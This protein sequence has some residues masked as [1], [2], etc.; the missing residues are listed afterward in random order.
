MVWSV[1][2]N[3]LSLLLLTLCVA[4]DSIPNLTKAA[5]LGDRV[6]GVL[7][8]QIKSRLATHQA[9]RSWPSLLVLVILGLSGLVSVGCDSESS[10]PYVEGIEDSSNSD[11]DAVGDL[12][13]QDAT[14]NQCAPACE[15]GESCDAQGLP[16]G[17]SCDGNACGM[18][19]TCQ[20]GEC[21]VDEDPCD[22]LNPCTEDLCDE[23]L[24]CIHVD[25]TGGEK[26]CGEGACQ[27]SIQECD[28]GNLMECPEVVISDEICDGLDNDCDGEIDEE[29]PEQTCG[30]GRCAS[31]AP[32]CVDGVVPDCVPDEDAAEPEACND[33]DDDCNGVVDDADAVGCTSFFFDGDE[34]G[35]GA[36]DAE[37]KCLCE[38][39]DLFTATESGD[40]DDSD[41]GSSPGAE[42]RCDGKDT[43]CDG[44]V[45]EAD[46]LDC[47]PHYV[48]E[49]ADGHGIESSVACLCQPDETH[50]VTVG[51]DCNDADGEVYP[52]VVESCNGKDDDCD[53]EID[54]EGADGCQNYYV[55]L[56]GDGYGVTSETDF[57]CYC[58]DAEHPAPYTAWKSDDCCDSDGNVRP[59]QSNY[60]QYPRQCGGFDYNCDGVETKQY[61]Q[62]GKCDMQGL[63]CDTETGYL[64][65]PA[66]CG[67]TKDWLLDCSYYWGVCEKD[68]KSQTQG[69]K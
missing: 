60:F 30:E 50:T 54:E 65:L 67:D 52:G 1:G 40:C 43:D 18:V 55:D 29:I 2:V 68:T 7:T 53:N 15:A 10:D 22:D 44:T 51:D 56:D 24:G 12:Y 25:I 13:A 41:A 63:T 33:K 61:T 8:M 23:T 64:G 27:T 66:A 17:E 26:I 69:C 19:S 37:V 28:G 32:G 3:Q 39:A 38:A 5:G 45:D 20:A 11:A 35:Y 42:E 36:D 14:L 46:A 34:D 4:L 31:T 58:P 47:I 16:E 6:E 9:R 49:D 62:V 57:H 48:D 59:G 21:V